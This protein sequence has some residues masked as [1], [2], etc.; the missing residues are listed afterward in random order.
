M[1][2]QFRNQNSRYIS[3]KNFKKEKYLN[4]NLTKLIQDLNADNYKH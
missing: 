4:I 3:F 2:K 1:L